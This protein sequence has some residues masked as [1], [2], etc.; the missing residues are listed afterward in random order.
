M[1]QV[2]LRVLYFPGNFQVR[3][4]HVRR[5]IAGKVA[6][7]EDLSIIA[8][9]DM[10]SK[11]GF[12]TKVSLCNF[13]DLPLSFDGQHHPSSYLL[14]IMYSSFCIFI[15]YIFCLQIY[16]F[17]IQVP[18][19]QQ[20]YVTLG[21]ASID[22]ARYVDSRNQT[23]ALPIDLASGNQGVLS[24]VISATAV[25]GLIGDD[26]GGS[27]ISG[28]SSS[29]LEQDQDLGGFEDKKESEMSISMLSTIPE[30]L[31]AGSGGP[32][33]PLDKNAASSARTLAPVP[34]Q[35]GS[36]PE[37]PAYGDTDEVDSRRADAA[38]RE[39]TRAQEREYE[40]QQ[41]HQRFPANEREWGES[42]QERDG[43]SPIS[44]Q[45]ESHARS[46]SA[47]AVEESDPS[48]GTYNDHGQQEYSEEQS[49]QRDGKHYDQDG[50]EGDSQ[51]YYD[52]H[53][54]EGEE[55]YYDENGSVEEG[56]YDEEGEYEEGEE[57]DE[58]YAEADIADLEARLAAAE[59]AAAEAETVAEEAVAMLETEQSERRQVEALLAQLQHELEFSTKKAVK[60]RADWE[61]RM[62]DSF[63]K[64][65]GTVLLTERVQREKAEL[66]D[67]MAALVAEKKDLEAMLD[68]DALEKR[69]KDA[70]TTAAAAAEA[71]ANI[72]ITKL[73]RQVQEME[74]YVEAADAKALAA[75]GKAAALETQL[76]G[77]R[78]ASTA[79]EWDEVKVAEEKADA[80]S[81]ELQ[82]AKAECRTLEGEVRAARE[83]ADRAVATAR[84]EAEGYGAR[85]ADLARQLDVALAAASVAER[86]VSQSQGRIVLLEDALERSNL[87]AAELRQRLVAAQVSPKAIGTGGELPAGL[88]PELA[89]AMQQVRE[90]QDA[91]EGR[92]AQ[93]AAT[94]RELMAVQDSL[95]AAQ[96][97]LH[98]TRQELADIQRIVSLRDGEMRQLREELRAKEA[99][100]AEVR[101]LQRDMAGLLAGGAAT[102]AA[103][104]H[105][106]PETP[107]PGGG[108]GGGGYSADDLALL[109]RRAKEAEGLARAA[110]MQTAD[111]VQQLGASQLEV[112]EG[113]AKVSEMREELARLR[114]SADG[115]QLRKIEA[116]ERELLVARNRAEVNNLF[117][118]EHERIA[119]DL[120]GTK[121]SLAESQEQLLVLRRSLIK[122]Q[123]RSMGFA[124]KLTRLETKLYKKLTTVGRRMSS[125]GAEW[126][127]RSKSEGAE[128][129]R[130]LS[131][132]AKAMLSAI[133][134]K[135]SSNRGGTGSSGGGGEKKPRKKKERSKEGN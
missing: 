113:A 13:I 118:E 114:S 8:T 14:A 36:R 2:A 86:N 64:M 9:L 65:E 23:V 59:A 38:S 17:R 5:V 68:R 35:S 27:V 111:L 50:H 63:K 58:Y 88:A 4:S 53:R 106:G 120:V 19:G 46:G 60:E 125:S 95:L 81:L 66:A 22:M 69:I 71:Q 52:E 11:G 47:A 75:Q 33:S 31:S 123:E 78:G 41:L 70:A 134:R 82:Y 121:L 15:F 55:G 43:M 29:G 112:Q 45:S 20:R 128:S 87:Q 131:S 42:S 54:A 24:V 67:R 90:V 83:D 44:R 124:A 101:R 48:H 135:N 3:R 80:L 77:V 98:A 92:A 39:R 85:A 102:K 12:G 104:L 10:N 126:G 94:S 130:K 56:T 105:A 34:E 76:A 6:W 26:E 127:E 84:R 61:A 103:V 133:R 116:L 110:A 1:H 18:D 7:G 28:L 30:S 49:S 93:L 37:S 119:N 99:Q 89:L 57:G 74:E 108:S 40:R 32:A 96:S 109:E 79:D 115:N 72:E 107:R 25:K 21:K 97:E 132:G 16:D 117:R 100:G 129:M 62:K 73:R 51:E 91:A 122:S